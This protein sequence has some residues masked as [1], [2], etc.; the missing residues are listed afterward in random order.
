MRSDDLADPHHGTRG[1]GANGLG[2]WWISPWPAPW[3]V[4]SCSRA[5]SCGSGGKGPWHLHPSTGVHGGRL[6]QREGGGKQVPI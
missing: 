4:G 3:L 5:R 2:P 6:A 1:Q